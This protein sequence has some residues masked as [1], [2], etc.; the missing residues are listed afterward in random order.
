VSAESRPSLSCTHSPCSL[1][2]L[3]GSIPFPRSFGCRIHRA[4]VHP[5]D[6]VA[7]DSLLSGNLLDAKQNAVSTQRPGDT[8]FKVSISKVPGATRVTMRLSLC[9]VGEYAALPFSCSH[10]KREIS[11]SSSMST[12]ADN[13]F[14]IYRHTRGSL[15]TYTSGRNEYHESSS[16]F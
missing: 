8:A 11:G 2:T 7:R 5:N 13:P 9:G 16:W 4:G 3:S 15:R 12:R 6:R 10:G 14:T 1:D